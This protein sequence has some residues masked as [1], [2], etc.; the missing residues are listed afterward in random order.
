MITDSDFLIKALEGLG[1]RW[2]TLVDGDDGGYRA[3]RAISKQVSR[4]I[5]QNSREVVILPDGADFERYLI[6]SGFQA[7]IRRGIADLYG[8][9]ALPRF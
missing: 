5:D 8:A 1:I 3:L 2:L 6:D 9:D 4:T 7:G